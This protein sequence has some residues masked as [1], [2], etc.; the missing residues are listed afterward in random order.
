MDMKQAGII[1][2]RLRGGRTQEAIAQAIGITVN[3]YSQ[4]E[5]GTRTPSDEKKERIATFYGTTA[6]EI[7]YKNGFLA[8]A[9]AYSSSLREQDDSVDSN[10][11]L[12]IVC[13]K[14]EVK[15]V[16]VITY[17]KNGGNGND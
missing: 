12:R 10:V 4:Y 15:N 2:K 1:L 8:N 13:K 16:K 6:E 3:A 11:T 7:F 9:P 5:Q 14:Q 17:C